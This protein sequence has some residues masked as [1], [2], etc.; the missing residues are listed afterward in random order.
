MFSAAPDRLKTTLIETAFSA[1]P[2]SS[3]SDPQQWA[4][5]IELLPEGSRAKGAESLARAWAL[6][7]PNEA[8][9]WAHSLPEGNMRNETAAAIASGWAAKD[10]HGAADWVASLPAGQERDRSAEALVMA[11]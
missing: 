8:I 3:S 11:V 1:L 7:A 6:Q 10:A 9:A 5:R 2:N 4:A